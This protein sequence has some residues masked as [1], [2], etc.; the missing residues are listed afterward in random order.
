[1]NTACGHTSARRE[2]LGIAAHGKQRA[3][4]GDHRAALERYREALRLAVAARE[5]EVFFRHYLE[6][7]LESLERLE[8]YAEV[9]EYCDRAIEHYRTTPPPH[10]LARV[11]LAHVHQRRGIVLLKQ[12]DPA[13]AAVALTEAARLAASARC[14]LPLT[15]AV[16]EWLN[17]GWQVDPERLL[18]EQERHRYFSVRPGA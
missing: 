9:L 17:R 10:D 5:P 2:H 18:A 7:A 12:R 15:A 13:R 1:M 4:A 6:C 3:L 11:D 8:A 16:L 14:A